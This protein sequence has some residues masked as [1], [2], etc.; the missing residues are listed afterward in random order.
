MNDWAAFERVWGPLLLH[1]RVDIGLAQVAWVLN[2]LFGKH[3]RSLVDF[4][5]SWYHD[6]EPVADDVML[7]RA[8]RLMEVIGHANHQ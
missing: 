3:S 4:L 2:S 8:K 6:R 5:P 1:E 7:E